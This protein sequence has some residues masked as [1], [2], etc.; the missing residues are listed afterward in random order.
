MSLRV[1]DHAAPLD[2]LG[3]LIA[4]HGAY[5]LADRGDEL[6]AEGRHAEAAELFRRASDLAPDNHELRF[7]AGLGAAQNGDLDT[8]VRDVRAAIAAQPGWR[9][10]L[11]RIPPEVAPMA[12]VV[13]ER[14]GSEDG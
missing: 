4:L 10:L 1:E 2:E 7:W 12:A 5:A 6:T 11:P 8:A 14:L 13:L 9:E 3:R